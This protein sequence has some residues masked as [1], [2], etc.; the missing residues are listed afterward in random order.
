MGESYYK[1]IDKMVEMRKKQDQRD[2]IGLI[3]AGVTAQI[4]KLKDNEHKKGF[5][6]VDI[7]Y[8]FGRIMQE[9]KELEHEIVF[10]ENIS[11]IRSKAADIANFCHMLIYRS[12]QE[13]RN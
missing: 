12:D 5:E 4:E 13:L 8:A 1:D 2:Y 11:A 7:M 6:D 3:N 10:T 9:V